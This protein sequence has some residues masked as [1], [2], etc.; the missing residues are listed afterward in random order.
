MKI[1]VDAETYTFPHIGIIYT[2]QT[3]VQINVQKIVMCTNICTCVSAHT[4][5]HPEVT[6]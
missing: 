3:R 5:T 4:H 2:P 1:Y 6:L